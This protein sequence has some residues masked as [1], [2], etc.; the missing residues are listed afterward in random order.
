MK[1]F[2][3]KNVQFKTLYNS[4][5]KKT[6][7][8]KIDKFDSYITVYVFDELENNVIKVL[9]IKK[10]WLLKEILS[11]L[12][13]C[14]MWE[15]VWGMLYTCL[16]I[17]PDRHNEWHLLFASVIHCLSLFYCCSQPVES[18]LLAFL[19]GRLYVKWFCFLFFF[20]GT[21][22]FDLLPCLFCF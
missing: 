22:C 5:K 4:K 3:E 18:A 11:N 12:S 14:T 9:R 17:S 1:I 2:K 13:W 6:F 10:N 21:I 7:S 8:V 15:V 16:L 20:C 19:G